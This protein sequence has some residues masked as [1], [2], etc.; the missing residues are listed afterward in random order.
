MDS[1]VSKGDFSPVQLGEKQLHPESLEIFNLYIRIQVRYQNPRVSRVCTKVS[2]NQ[3][4][5]G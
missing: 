2:R 3:L 5:D 4:H 1:E